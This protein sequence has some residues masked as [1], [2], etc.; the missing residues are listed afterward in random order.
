MAAD[1]EGK[2]RLPRA[3]AFDGGDEQ[4]A[5]IEYGGERGEPA[6]VIVLRAVVAKNGV[7]D[8]GFEHGRAP[9]LPLRQQKRKRMMAAAEVVPK[10][11][12]AGGWRRA[13]ASVKQCHGDL[14]F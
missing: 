12:L 8:V 3:G 13:G 7:R 4:R 6:L 11:Q 5:G 1:G 9:V 2:L 10:K 14:A